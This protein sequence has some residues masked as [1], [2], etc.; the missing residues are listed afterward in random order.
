MADLETVKEKRVLKSRYIPRRP[1]PQPFYSRSFSFV[2]DRFSDSFTRPILVLIM[3][4]L[5]FLAFVA[6]CLT[7]W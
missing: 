1:R 4:A 5:F 3:L 7:N 6:L 2:D